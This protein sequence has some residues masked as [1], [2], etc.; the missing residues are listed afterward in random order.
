[1]RDVLRGVA[2]SSARRI[3]DYALAVEVVLGLEVIAASELGEERDVG[4]RT[5]L[6]GKQ[7]LGRRGVNRDRTKNLV[8]RACVDSVVVIRESTAAGVMPHRQTDAVDGHPE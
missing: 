8:E 1:M 5:V 2:I 3:G 6:P 7:V 4:G